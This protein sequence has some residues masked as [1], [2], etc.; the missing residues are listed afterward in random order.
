MVNLSIAIISSQYLWCMGALLGDVHPSELERLYGYC[1][2]YVKA[3]WHGC[4]VEVSIMLT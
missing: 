4:K 2:E 1:A 3:S